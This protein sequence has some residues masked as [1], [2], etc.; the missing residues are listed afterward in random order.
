MLNR[1][2]ARIEISSAPAVTSSQT[3]RPP[4]LVESLRA[5]VALPTLRCST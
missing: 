3:T 1:A 2:I 4:T 5:L